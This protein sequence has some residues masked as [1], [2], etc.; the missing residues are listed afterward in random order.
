MDYV[1][2]RLH[3][4]RLPCH[5]WYRSLPRYFG[6][7]SNK[8]QRFRLRAVSGTVLCAIVFQLGR[9]KNSV[10]NTKRREKLTAYTSRFSTLPVE[11]TGNSF[12]NSTSLIALKDATFSF[13]KSMISSTDMAVSSF[14]TM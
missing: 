9:R 8:Q 7:S 3:C 6:T 10:K 13:T 1:R 5:R 11:L 2:C 12:L 4:D 14:R